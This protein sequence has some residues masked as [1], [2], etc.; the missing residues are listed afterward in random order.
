MLEVKKSSQIPK[1][2]SCSG[3]KSGSN[4]VKAVIRSWPKTC[5]A[6]DNDNAVDTIEDG[7]DPGRDAARDAGRDPAR[8]RG[9][10]SS[11]VGSQMSNV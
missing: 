2:S 4:E 7:R 10:L 9:I 3:F 5:I 11:G 6:G 1:F 8:D